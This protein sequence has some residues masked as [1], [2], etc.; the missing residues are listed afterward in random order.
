MSVR[1]RSKT[2]QRRSPDCGAVAG[3]VQGEKVKGRRLRHL[4]VHN[5]KG[6]GDD[7]L[8]DELKKQDQIAELLLE[9][10]KVKGKGPRYVGWDANEP[11]VMTVKYKDNHSDI[12]S[13]KVFRLRC[14]WIIGDEG[15][16]MLIQTS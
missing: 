7:E 6:A 4:S 15:R 9:I 3:D 10:T 8:Q 1:G 11:S 16:R 12:L 13:M 2:S 14:K 5:C